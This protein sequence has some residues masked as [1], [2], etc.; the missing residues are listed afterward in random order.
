MPIFKTG[1][2][3]QAGGV[4]V[5]YQ[6][7]VRRVVCAKCSF[8]DVGGIRVPFILHFADEWQGPPRQTCIFAFGVRRICLQRHLRPRLSAVACADAPSVA[9]AT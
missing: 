6:E 8:V 9:L 3:A 4:C 7:R 2:T 1:T 5:D